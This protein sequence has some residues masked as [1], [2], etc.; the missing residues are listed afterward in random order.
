MH[1][2]LEWRLHNLGIICLFPGKVAEG[3]AL[4]DGGERS[5]LSQEDYPVGEGT[6]RWRNDNKSLAGIRIRHWR[7]CFEAGT[8]E[9]TVQR[10][11]SAQKTIAA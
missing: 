10:T 9:T 4:G 3:V 1:V 8:P 7:A 6:R 2:S 5:G 11:K